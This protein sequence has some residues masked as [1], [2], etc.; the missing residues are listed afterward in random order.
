ML[1]E[2]S[3]ESKSKQVQALRCDHRRKSSWPLDEQS[4]IRGHNTTHSKRR[5]YRSKE[6]QAY[7]HGLLKSNNVLN[8]AM[9]VSSSFARLRGIRKYVPQYVRQSGETQGVL[10]QLRDEANSDIVVTEAAE[11]EHKK[12]LMN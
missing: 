12:T 1:E 10:K 6:H 9:K 2:D 5:S 4:N 11:W 8:R 7:P 3:A